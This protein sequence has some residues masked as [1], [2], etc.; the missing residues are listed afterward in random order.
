VRKDCAN[1]QAVSLHET[2]VQ[3]PW[4]CSQTLLTRAEVNFDVLLYDEHDISAC[5]LVAVC[6]VLVN[7]T[8]WGSN[9]STKIV[10]FDLVIFLVP[11]RKTACKPY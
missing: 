7:P 8:L 11:K 6:V 2:S 4:V 10:I 3:A 9:V 1:L 5:A